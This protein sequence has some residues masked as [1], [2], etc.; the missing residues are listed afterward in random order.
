MRRPGQPR[1][2][3]EPRDFESERGW[4]H[5]IHIHEESRTLCISIADAVELRDALT[6]ALIHAQGHPCSSGPACSRKGRLGR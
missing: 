6:D 2:T 3:Y 5:S 1:V 4:D